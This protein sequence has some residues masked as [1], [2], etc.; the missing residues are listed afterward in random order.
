MWL[1]FFFNNNKLARWKMLSIKNLLLPTTFNRINWLRWGWVETWHSYNPASR[2]WVNLIWRVQSSEGRVRTM[3]NRWSDAY[4]YRPTVRMCTSR[5][6]TQETYSSKKSCLINILISFHSR[7]LSQNDD[8]LRDK[9][10]NDIKKI[11]GHL[12]P[13]HAQ[14]SKKVPSSN[15]LLLK[16][17]KV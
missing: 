6:R 10:M 12:P 9:E 16:M 7:R 3:L 1:V 11:V 13:I 8:P 5:W 2:L 14:L 15:R 4:V 17:M